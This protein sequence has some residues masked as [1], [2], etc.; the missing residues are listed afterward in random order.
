[1]KGLILALL[2]PVLATLQAT[3]L[4]QGLP[5]G[6]TWDAC[7]WLTVFCGLRWGAAAGSAAGLWAGTLVGA[8]FSALGGFYALLYGLAGWL[9]GCHAERSSSRQSD[10]LAGWA[11]MVL[12]L[13][14]E[15]RLAPWFGFAPPSLAWTLPTLAWQAL[16]CLA[17]VKARR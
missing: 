13:S 14:L 16:F 7:L 4:W 6:V 2:F 3:V 17:L 9:A 5:G 12:V 11:V 8:L 15:A 1:M 10:P